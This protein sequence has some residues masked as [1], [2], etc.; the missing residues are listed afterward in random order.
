L[1]NGTVAIGWSLTTG[2]LLIKM[3]CEKSRERPVT[4]RNGH[5]EESFLQQPYRIKAGKSL[6]QVVIIQSKLFW[7]LAKV[8]DAHS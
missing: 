4:G 2:A 3:Q 7:I 8:E 5:V 1:Q 6:E